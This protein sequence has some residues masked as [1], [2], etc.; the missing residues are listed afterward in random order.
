MFRWASVR[1]LRVILLLV[2][3]LNLIMVGIQLLLDP[4]ILLMPGGLRSALD[5]AAV[6]ALV[7]LVVFWTT[8]W[9]GPVAQAVLS[10]GTIAGLVSGAVEIVHITIENFGSFDARI[11]SRLT[12]FFLLALLLIW[13]VAGFRSTRSAAD[14]GAGPLAGSWSAMVGM[15]MATTY[16]FSQLYWCLPRLE[17]RNVG[18]P[19][20]LRSGWT[21]LHIFTIADVFEAGF[22]ILLV[23]P[24]LGA[25]L[26]A[27]G[28]IAARTV[29]VI[30]GRRRA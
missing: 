23:G 4:Q 29:S 12:G 26:G 5:A 16:G 13:G 22:K 17:H 27:L 14:P 20:F 21:D 11:E 28:A 6:L 18:S 8:R 7:A 15:L 3:A 1:A 10:D 19:D 9:N 24:V 30:R 2:I 25:V